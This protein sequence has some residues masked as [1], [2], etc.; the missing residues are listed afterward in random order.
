MNKTEYIK[1]SE[2]Y[3]DYHLIR[4][5]GGLV[6][7][8]EAS[9]IDLADGTSMTFDDGDGWFSLGHVSDEDNF[10]TA[11]DN[12]NE[13]YRCQLADLREEFGG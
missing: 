11:C 6:I 1:Q 10:E 7:A 3:P 12:L 5:N 2:F 9:S 4:R 13:E 8:Q